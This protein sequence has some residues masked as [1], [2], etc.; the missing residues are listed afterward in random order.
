MKLRP[1]EHWFSKYED[2]DYYEEL[3]NKK[4]SVKYHPHLG[5]G[6]LGITGG[7]GGGKLG[8][9]VSKGKRAGAATGAIIGAAGAGYAGWKLGKMGKKKVEKQ[10]EK[11]RRRYEKA[12]ESDRKYLRERKRQKDAEERE[13]RRTRA[14]EMMGYNSFRW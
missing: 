2:E 11:D 12:S 10:V 3:D 8:H 5:A 9:W 4:K 6:I 7:V 1:Y 14:Q 13:E